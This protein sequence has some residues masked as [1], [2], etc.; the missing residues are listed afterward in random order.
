[1]KHNPSEELCL[2]VICYGASDLPAGLVSHKRQLLTKIALKKIKNILK[3]DADINHLGKNFVTNTSQTPLMSARRSG[4]MRIV[5][6]LLSN[7]ADPKIKDEHGKD[8]LHWF[9]KYS[10]GIGGYNLDK[11]TAHDFK[12]KKLIRDW[13]LIKVQKRYKNKLLKRRINKRIL[14]KRILLD[15]TRLPYELIN[16]IKKLI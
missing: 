14:T 5:K 15:K 11:M 16:K 13:P 8:V 4:N 10:R 7:G 2:A 3:K 6:F 1:M 9:Y 12:I